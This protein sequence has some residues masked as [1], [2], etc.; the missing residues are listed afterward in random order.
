[1]QYVD[2]NGDPF[3]VNA[4]TT[5]DMLSTPRE[6][7]LA[8][9]EIA[10]EYKWR[11]NP[12][13]LERVAAEM[14]RL[15]LLKA[16]QTFVL[17]MTFDTVAETFIR[18]TDALGKRI[19]LRVDPRLDPRSVRK[20]L[21][22]NPACETPKPGLAWWWIDPDAYMPTLQDELQYHKY[23]GEGSFSV[24]CDRCF[25]VAELNRPDLAH[26]SVLAMALMHP[27]WLPMDSHLNALRM[28]GYLF[29]KKPNDPQDQKYVELDRGSSR[30]SGPRLYGLGLSWFGNLQ[31]SAIPVARPFQFVR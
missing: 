27:R 12:T 3:P 30:F 18:Y 6:Q 22:L 15:P 13:D 17:V 28:G 8:F 7:L 14:D 24:F 31:Q 19:R 29:A 26:A 5:A 1:M 20:Y 21:R 25:A 11:V 16:P 23:G 2:K 10:L 9:T 4:R